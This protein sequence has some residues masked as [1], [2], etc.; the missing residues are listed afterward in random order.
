MRKL[1][2]R[3]QRLRRLAILCLLFVTPKEAS[4]TCWEKV[5]NP[6]LDA[7]PGMNQALCGSCVWYCLGDACAVGDCND[8]DYDNDGNPDCRCEMCGVEY[9]DKI[10][11]S[12]TASCV[13]S[14][15]DEDGN[16]ISADGVAEFVCPGIEL[17]TNYFGGDCNC[18]DEDDLVSRDGL[19]LEGI[20]EADDCVRKCDTYGAEYYVYQSN[21]NKCWCKTEEGYNVRLRVQRCPECD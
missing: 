2:L 12:S 5:T 16:V 10:F 13:T 17:D 7:D 8:G 14:I 3:Q 6:Y 4:G 18:L 19:F 1:H 11:D 15:T 9:S 21:S 20:S